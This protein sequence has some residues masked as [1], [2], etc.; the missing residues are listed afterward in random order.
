MRTGAAALGTLLLLLPCAARAAQE[1]GEEPPSAPTLGEVEPGDPAYRFLRLGVERDYLAAERRRLVDQI[2]QAIPPLYEP[3]L[4]FHGYT[5]PPGAWRVGA[6]AVYGHNPGDFGRDDFYSLFFDNVRVDFLNPSIDISRGFEI[7]SL[8]RLGSDLVMNLNIPY[9]FQ[10][11][12]GTG[13]PFRIDPMV[14]TM[15]GAGN[16]FGDVSATLKKKWLDQGNGPVTL[17]TML[18]VIFPTAEDDQV[19]NASQT[20]FVN[21]VP[22][23]VSSLVPGNPAVDIFGRGA[24]GHNDRLFP[25]GGQPGNGSWGGRIG[26]GVT[27]Q[28]ERSALHGGAVFDAF[29]DNDGITPGNELRYGASYVFPPFESDRFSLDFSIFG[30]W[31]ESERFPGTITHPE[32]DPATGGAKMNPDG[33]TAMFTTP[34]PA[35]EHGNMVFFSPSIIFLPSPNTRLTLSPAIRISEPKK[36]PSPEWT[37]RTGMTVTF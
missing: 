31:K 4:P 16:G 6:S 1:E 3:V 29:A 37:L 13:H 10:R 34:R 20:M 11:T 25:R 15:E 8:G 9:S 18:G 14:M 26:F 27:R 21:G 28:F 36:G 32:R 17:S 33:T 22:M 19:F 35:F 24:G 5:L 2:E 30:R 7:P 23:S 12:R